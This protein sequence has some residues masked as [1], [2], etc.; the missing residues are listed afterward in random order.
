M[1]KEILEGGFSE[2]L[3][4][5]LILDKMQAFAWSAC[6]D[7]CQRIKK[8]EAGRQTVRD[9]YEA[10]KEK[11]AEEGRR[12][13][14]AN[15]PE[16]RAE[17]EAKRKEQEE[18]WQLAREKAEDERKHNPQ[19]LCGEVYFNI[20][21]KEENR[22]TFTEKQNAILGNYLRQISEIAAAAN[23]GDA[24]AEII[25]MTERRD[26]CIEVAA[27]VLGIQQ[28]L[29]DLDYLVRQVSVTIESED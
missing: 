27:Y 22:T 24:L 14:E 1:A 5:I 15:T 25:R 6:Q 11:A 21:R 26:S 2:D 4:I 29:F 12:K 7:L 18:A 28:G 23:D 10:A 9:E 19:W 8:G 3:E 13:D 16:K 20:G 17:I